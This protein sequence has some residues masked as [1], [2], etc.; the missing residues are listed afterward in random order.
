[1]TVLFILTTTIF[2]YTEVVGH[3]MIHIVLIIFI[4]EGIPFYDPPISIHKI[5]I[6]QLIFVFLNF[7]YVLST[8]LLNY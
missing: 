8:F 2:G 6:N 5:R 4:I 7:L 1:M 3:R